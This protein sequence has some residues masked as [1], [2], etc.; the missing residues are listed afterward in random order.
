VQSAW[1]LKVSLCIYLVFGFFDIP[2]FFS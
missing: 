1:Y 2:G